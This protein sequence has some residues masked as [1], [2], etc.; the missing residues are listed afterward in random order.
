MHCGVTLS[1]QFLPY[2]PSWVPVTKTRGGTPIPYPLAPDR[3]SCRVSQSSI[4]FMACQSLPCPVDSIAQCGISLPQ[5]VGGAAPS[6][7]SCSNYAT[8]SW[9]E[10]GSDGRC[11]FLSGLLHQHSS[12][13]PLA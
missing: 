1:Y 2:L 8:G 3:E 13:Q 5:E 7:A 6:P 11:L 4:D 10:L 12:L 9:T